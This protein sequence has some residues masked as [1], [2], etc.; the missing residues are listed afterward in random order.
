MADVVQS[1][2]LTAAAGRMQNAEVDVLLLEPDHVAVNGDASVDLTALALAMLAKDANVPLYLITDTSTM[3]WD[4]VDGNGIRKDITADKAVISADLIHGIVTERG[5][6]HKEG[7]KFDVTSLD[8]SG[9]ASN[10]LCKF[11]EFLPLTEETAIEYIQANPSFAKRLGPPGVQLKCWEAK[12]GNINYIYIV[13]G[14]EG[15]LVIKQARPYIRV[16]GESW[17]LTQVSFIQMSHQKE[18]RVYTGSSPY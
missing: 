18:I 17:P 3:R 14:P 10:S 13:E 1:V 16:V 6:L 2:S 5:I 15:G 11:S 4:V 12:D 9:K 8:P 7:T